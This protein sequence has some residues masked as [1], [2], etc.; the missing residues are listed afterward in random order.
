MIGVQ[1]TGQT[2]ENLL[3][4]MKLHIIPEGNYVRI[5]VSAIDADTAI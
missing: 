1:T 3:D 2:F 4:N 5:K